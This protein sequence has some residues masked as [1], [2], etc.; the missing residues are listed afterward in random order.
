MQV[1]ASGCTVLSTFFEEG[2]LHGWIGGLVVRLLG[3]R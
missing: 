1:G 3:W 2:I